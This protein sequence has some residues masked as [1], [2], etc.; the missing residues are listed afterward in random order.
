M[1][2]LFR[3]YG[4]SDKPD[5]V[6]E[7]KMD[8]LKEDVVQLVSHVKVV[9]QFHSVFPCLLQIKVLGSDKCILVAHDWGG[10]IAWCVRYCTCICMHVI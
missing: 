6:G 9:I 10:A 5:A 3:G 1:C 8:I 2:I 4:D 7:Y